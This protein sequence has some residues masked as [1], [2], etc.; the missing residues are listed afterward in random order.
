MHDC[1]I[2]NFLE[3]E[4]HTDVEITWENDC[5]LVNN[6]GQCKVVGFETED[7]SH[8]PFLSSWEQEVWTL[9]KTP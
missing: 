7:S 5:V 3:A 2:L 8:D 4:D 6:K 1:F 9:K